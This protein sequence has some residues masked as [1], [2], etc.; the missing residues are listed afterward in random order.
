[1][2]SAAP[3]SPRW[4]TTESGA[5][6]VE[7]GLAQVRATGESLQALA[8]IVHDNRLAVREISDTVSQQD[9]GIAQ[10]FVAL[11]DLSTLSQETVTRLNATQEA[12]TRLFEVSREVTL[13]STSTS[14]ERGLRASPRRCPWRAPSP[15]PARSPGRAGRCAAS[16]DPRARWAG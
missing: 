2:T 3:S 10:L 1:M 14:S 8:S 9:A 15:S 11:K 16:T 4:S 7:G 6:E 12:A 13:M 5:R